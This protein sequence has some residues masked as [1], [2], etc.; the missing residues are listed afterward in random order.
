MSNHHY[1]VYP[2]EPPPS[3]EEATGAATSSASPVP[4]R[5]PPRLPPRNPTSTTTNPVAPSLLSSSPTSPVAQTPSH[6]RAA[7]YNSNNPFFNTS[8]QNNDANTLNIPPTPQ[9]YRRHS[10]AGASYPAFPL[11]PGAP[12]HPP[13]QTFAQLLP[14]SQLGHPRQFPPSINLY[15]DAFPGALQRRYFLGEHQATPL[16]AVAAWLSSPHHNSP[17]LSSAHLSSSLVLH[18]GPSE[19]YATL[20]TASY[21]NVWGGRRNMHVLLPPLPHQEQ[22]DPIMVQTGTSMILGGGVG[23][24]SF[25]FS[26]E[27]PWP[28]T[29]NNHNDNNNNPDENGITWRKEPYEWRRS[30]SYAVGGLGGSSQ[31]WKLVRMSNEL[32]PGGLA[33]AGSGPPSGDGHEVVAVCTN[34]VMSMTKLWKFS[35]LGTGLS[36]A[37]GERWAVMAVMTGLVIWDRDSRRDGLR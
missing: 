27:V 3:Y 24:L 11:T 26:V 32:P 23:G 7:S 35:F 17:L 21:D 12:H 34:A 14:S 15:R 16:Y 1:D 30:N 22:S 13:A 9:Q 28:G 33:V 37:L 6:G 18:N 2:D 20:A 4:P 31:G 36:G 10:S 25:S 29:P 5:L 19:D 8:K